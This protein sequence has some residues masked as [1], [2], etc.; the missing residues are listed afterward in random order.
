M[1][2]RNMII[3]GQLQFYAEQ[4]RY[5]RGDDLDFRFFG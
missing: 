3:F 2:V 5:L 4:L 1:F